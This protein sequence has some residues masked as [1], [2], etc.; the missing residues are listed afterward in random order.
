MAGADLAWRSAMEL[1]GL[2]RDKQVSPVEVMDA[3]L[4]RI[5]AL[6]PRINA[7]CTVA[8]EEARDAALAAEVAVLSGE[9]GRASCRG[10]V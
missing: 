9:I 3:V 10:R 2:I 4:A 1:A 6:N 5:A 7:F 8:G